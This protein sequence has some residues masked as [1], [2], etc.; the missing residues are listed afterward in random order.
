METSRCGPSAAVVTSS[1]SP[2]RPGLIHRSLRCD[3]GDGSL[4]ACVRTTCSGAPSS[5]ECSEIPAW[6]CGERRYSVLHPSLTALHNL[7]ARRE[8]PMQTAA[9]L[10]APVWR[11]LWGTFP[12]RSCPAPCSAALPPITRVKI[13]V[14][15]CSCPGCEATSPLTSRVIFPCCSEILI[16]ATALEPPPLWARA[17]RSFCSISGG[18]ASV[19]TSAGPTAFTAPLCSL[20][21]SLSPLSRS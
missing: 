20:S 16:C 17:F 4:P 14:L 12:S 18:L 9:E 10:I 6:V 2:L 15:W 19:S 8:Q 13:W 3:G 11:Q 1:F 7:I 21:F 5:S